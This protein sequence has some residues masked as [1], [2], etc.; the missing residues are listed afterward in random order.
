M[1][2]SVRGLKELL[3]RTMWMLPAKHQRRGPVMSGVKTATNHCVTKACQSL[4]GVME[5]SLG[6]ADVV[7]FEK[8]RLSHYMGPK[9]ELS[10]KKLSWSYKTT[11]KIS[12]W[13][14]VQVQILGVSIQ[15]WRA[16]QALLERVSWFMP[17]QFSEHLTLCILPRK[18]PIRWTVGNNMARQSLSELGEMLEQYITKASGASCS[19]SCWKQ[20]S[21]RSSSMARAGGVAT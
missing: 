1:K 21:F 16:F 5:S 10:C 11:N 15:I 18:L 7:W 4:L 2:G 8:D 17:T 6:K 13:A 20:V 19:N 9:K 3:R 14:V 12:R